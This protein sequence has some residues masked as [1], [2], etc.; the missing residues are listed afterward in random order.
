MAWTDLNKMYS[1]FQFLGYELEGSTSVAQ[2]G[3]RGSSSKVQLSC[4]RP[5]I[6]YA[7][8][9]N[10]SIEF[11]DSTIDQRPMCQRATVRNV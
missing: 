6:E 10:A 2:S 8:E 4:F 7:T 3:T 1:N 9:M 5:G 11:F